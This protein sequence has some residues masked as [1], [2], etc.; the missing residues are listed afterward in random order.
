MQKQR[1][2]SGKKA[3]KK[4]CCWFYNNNLRAE[5]YTFACQ[6]SILALSA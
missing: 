3:N 2:L 5:F 1:T 4:N 6:K